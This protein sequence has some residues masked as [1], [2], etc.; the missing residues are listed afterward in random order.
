MHRI[1]E[2][3]RPETAELL[4]AQAR[5][6]GLS[7]DDYLSTLLPSANRQGEEKPLYERATPEEW[8]R[9]LREWAASHRVLPVIADDSRE[10]IY[11]GRGQ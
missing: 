2:Q 8:T 3:I 5:A 1:L 10:S 9:A 4:A 11:E 7:V 6:L